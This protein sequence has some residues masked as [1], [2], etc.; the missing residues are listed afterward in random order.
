M[1]FITEYNI[2]FSI[3]L[4][5][6]MFVANHFVEGIITR[7]HSESAVKYKT[8]QKFSEEQFC[9]I[10][11]IYTQQVNNNKISLMKQHWINVKIQIYESLFQRNIQKFK[12]TY[13]DETNA[14]GSFYVSIKLIHL[15]L[16]KTEKQAISSLQFL[17]EHCFL[18]TVCQGQKGYL[19][20]YLLTS[21]A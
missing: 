13:M 8:R 12:S 4:L 19:L 15:Q 18:P 2:L 7:G 16:V 20:V 21:S 17:V 5:K 10:Y 14:L 6:T 11:F 3:L 9:F 1:S